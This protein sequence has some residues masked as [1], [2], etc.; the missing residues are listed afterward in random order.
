MGKIS[1]LNRFSASG[2]MMLCVTAGITLAA[3]VGAGIVETMLSGDR[4]GAPL[5]NAIPDSPKQS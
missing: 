1:E 4:T 5:S 3:L 2:L